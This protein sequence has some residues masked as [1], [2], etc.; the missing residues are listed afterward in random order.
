MVARAL[1]VR[2]IGAVVPSAAPAPAQRRRSVN[3]L[4]DVPLSYRRTN[5]PWRNYVL[6]DRGISMRWLGLPMNAIGKECLH[7]RETD[8]SAA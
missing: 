2:A 1:A 4:S 8:R 7:D 5:G 3:D 6:P